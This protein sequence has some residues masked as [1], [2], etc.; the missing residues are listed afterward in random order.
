MPKVSI[1]LTLSLI[2]VLALAWG[3]LLNTAFA[4]E[5]DGNFAGYPGYAA[6][7][8]APSLDSNKSSV[9]GNQ[10]ITLSGANFS[11][12]ESISSITIADLTI[13]GSHINDGDDI[14]IASDGSW[15][16]KVI[17]PSHRDMLTA[18]TKTIKATDS[19]D[20][21]A[22]TRV[23]FSSPRFSISP[24][25]GERDSWVTARGRNFPVTKSSGVWGYHTLY[26][27]YKEQGQC[28]IDNSASSPSYLREHPTPDANGDFDFEF[29]VPLA[30]RSLK[31][32]VGLWLVLEDADG[33]FTHNM[34]VT[35]RIPAPPT[36]TPKPTPTPGP[37]ATPEPPRYST[38]WTMN[39]ETG[40]IGSGITVQGYGF[41]PIDR[42]IRVSYRYRR[43]SDGASIGLIGYVVDLDENGDFEIE[44]TVPD[45]APTGTNHI[46]VN[47]WDYYDERRI[48]SRKDHT[49][50]AETTPT[51]TPTPE[52]TA[53][54][55]PTPTPTPV[56]TAT[57]VP[58]PTATP[59]PGVTPAPTPPRPTATPWPTPTPTP[60]P[61][62]TPQPTPTPVP[63][64][65]PTTPPPPA[66]PTQLESTTNEPPHIFSGRATIDGVSAGAGVAIDAYDGNNVLVGATTTTAG[67]RFY[68]HVHRAANPIS[69]QVNQRTAPQ[70]WKT[71][72]LGQI[73]ANFNLTVGNAADR[74]DAA[75]LFDALPDLVRAFRFDNQTKE[76]SFFDRATPEVNTLLQF[77]PQQSYWLLVS[78]TTN[79]VFNAVERQLFCKEGNCWNVIVW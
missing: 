72:Q 59:Q 67:G 70:T 44:F 60:W 57:P 58:A 16:A 75:W 24:E 74:T 71:W 62:A 79:L 40:G 36:P 77:V 48:S 30:V 65:T 34:S 42:D 51:P 8:G 47:Y 73:T 38:W 64:P 6:Q 21:A 23:S 54:P 39:P 46:E 11:P 45:D 10:E 37:T 20:R 35:H 31:N 32:C 26:L 41:N 33:F 1:L 43:S 49:V 28:G 18:S 15:R 78:R 56:P 61:T 76:W 29:R 3:W 66:A 63:T 17:L 4:G 25:T 55:V 19:G 7:D 53:T 5:S 13:P 9:V 68:I 27:T 14:S 12:D 22:E 2:V 50:P 52:P 69:F